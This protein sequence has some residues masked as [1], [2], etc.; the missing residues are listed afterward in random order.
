MGKHQLLVFTAGLML[1]AATVPAD[2]HRRPVRLRF[3]MHD[4]TGG[5]GQTAVL[6]VRGTGPPNPSMP[7]G[8]N[9]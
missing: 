9:C 5:P 1:T 2:A 8:A 4:I 6:L 3:Y 7:D